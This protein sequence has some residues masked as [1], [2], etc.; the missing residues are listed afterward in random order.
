MEIISSS[1]KPLLVSKSQSCYGF[2][3]LMKLF[4]LVSNKLYQTRALLNNLEIRGGGRG[5]GGGNKLVAVEDIAPMKT[6]DEH[7]HQGLQHRDLGITGKIK[8][9]FKSWNY[10][11]VVQL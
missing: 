11:L 9:K 10:S 4:R 2:L 5:D 3:T 6:A 7:F 1:S 8:L